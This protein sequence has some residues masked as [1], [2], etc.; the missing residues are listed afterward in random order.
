MYPQV[1]LGWHSVLHT[2][3]FQRGFKSY[4]NL[5]FRTAFYAVLVTTILIGTQVGVKYSARNLVSY[6]AQASGSQAIPP[7][8]IL[9]LPVAVA[10]TPEQPQI[11]PVNPSAGLQAVLDQWGTD[12]G[13]HSWSVVVQGLGDDSRSASL[14]PDKIRPAASIYKLFLTYPLFKRLSVADLPNI[15][16]PGQGA[17]Q[18]LAGCVDLM[19]RVSDN[20]CGLAV[21]KYVGWG[22]ADALLARAGFGST[23]LNTTDGTRTSARD[24]AELLKSLYEARLYDSATRDYLMNILKK[25]ALN[26]GIPTGCQGCDVA[27]KTGDFGYVRHDAAI[28]EHGGRAYVLAIFT[29]GASYAEIAGLTSKVRAV[30]AH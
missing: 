13:G 21:G 11:A 17:G 25:Q 14:N 2:P 20:P 7:K 27:N 6:Q 1:Q 18:S 5:A 26:K 23:K 16:L 19:L 28:I 9:P 24:T 8:P 4:W 15:K 29:S 22:Q 12:H 3:R 30:M 10:T